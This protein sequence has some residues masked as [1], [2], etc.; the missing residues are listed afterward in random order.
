M[1]RSD[2]LLSSPDSLKGLVIFLGEPDTGKSFLAQRLFSLAAQAGKKVMLLD[3][4]VGQQSLAYPGTVSSSSKLSDSPISYDR[5]RFIG[6]LNPFTRMNEIIESAKALLSYS[7]GF[8]LILVDTSG[9]TR[10]EEG[11]ILK[12]K[13]IR[14][15]RPDLIIA[16]EKEDE[17]EHI[18][19]EVTQFETIRVQPSENI[20]L[21]TREM[22]IRRRNERL[23]SYFRSPLT[24]F[25]FK[26]KYFK[27]KP[28]NERLE[29]RRGRI[30]GLNS[31]TETIGLGVIEEGNSESVTFLSPLPIDSVSQIKEIVVGDRTLELPPYSC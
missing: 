16:I 20:T 15:L 25:S 30:I 13:K 24:L 7:F 12:T 23:I 1:L 5:M 9:L 26:L 21:K 19:R 28:E 11:R 3:L 17:L 10:G 27:L 31:K 6:T 4:D 29:L 22:R 14:E 18:L 8:E 2:D